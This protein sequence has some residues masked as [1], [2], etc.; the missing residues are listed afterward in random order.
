[1]SRFHQS[2]P[3]S[4]TTYSRFTSIEK[5]LNEISN[6]VKNHQLNATFDPN[7]P[8]MKHDLLGFAHIAKIWP[9]REILLDT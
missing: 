6:M 2:S 7:Y 9:Y 1:M 5:T 4:V 3:N 8:K